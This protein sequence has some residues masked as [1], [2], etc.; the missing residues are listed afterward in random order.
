MS[1]TVSY[2]AARPEAAE[3]RAEIDAA[4]IH[5]HVAQRDEHLRSAEFFDVANHPKL[6]FRSTGI[7]VIKDG[8]LEVLG[9]L[10]LH[11]TTRPITLTVIDVT[12][13]QK[14]H[15]GKTRIGASATATIKRSDF[16][17]T[18]NKVLEAGGVA[19]ADQVSLTLDVSLVK[20]V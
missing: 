19:L 20:E 7:R 9:D 2:D 1:A 4:S 3:I 16:G 5:T 10:T 6:T 17:M 18:Y 11:G 15:N 14:D 13:E 12:G 8:E